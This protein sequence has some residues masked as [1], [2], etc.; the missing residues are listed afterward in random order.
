MISGGHGA[1][2][3]GRQK[4]AGGGGGSTGNSF[5]QSKNRLENVTFIKYD[6]G[7][8]VIASPSIKTG[9]C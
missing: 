1:A 6:C 8:K 3:M 2:P 4:A 9:C 5:T 7:G